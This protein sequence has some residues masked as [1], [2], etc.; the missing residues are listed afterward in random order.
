L[1]EGRINIQQLAGNE[2]DDFLMMRTDAGHIM[3][4]VVPPLLGQQEGLRPDAERLLAPGGV[5]EAV[6]AGQGLD[7]AIGFFLSHRGEQI[8]R[9]AAAFAERLL[10]HFQLFAR[11]SLKVQRPVHVSERQRGRGHAAGKPA[12]QHVPHPV[13]RLESRLAGGIG[14]S[15]QGCRAAIERLAC[16]VGFWASGFCSGAMRWPVRHHPIREMCAFA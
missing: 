8:G 15:W 9:Q 5:T 14:I 7:T 4:Q 12:D 13:H 2:G 6:V 11:R 16:F 10:D 3:G 1:F